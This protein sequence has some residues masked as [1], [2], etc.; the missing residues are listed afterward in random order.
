MKGER[1]LPG[2]HRSAESGGVAFRVA[3]RV[4]VDA[5][6]RCSPRHSNRRDALGPGYVQPVGA[7]KS[8]GRATPNGSRVRT[9]VLVRFATDRLLNRGQTRGMRLPS[10]LGA[11]PL[12]ATFHHSGITLLTNSSS[13]ICLNATRR[14]IAACSFKL[15][16]RARTSAGA[17]SGV[18]ESNGGAGAYSRASCR[19]CAVTASKSRRLKLLVIFGAGVTSS[20]FTLT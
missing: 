20:S 11:R 9:H 6:S 5:C 18:P 7:R 10:D 13:L 1:F 19:D 16:T 12:S 14:S 17:R 15:L 2:R 4:G 8:L 3:A